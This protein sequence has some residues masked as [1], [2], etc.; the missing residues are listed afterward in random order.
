MNLVDFI[1]FDDLKLSDIDT[2]DM[3]VAQNKIDE[4]FKKNEHDTYNRITCPHCLQE[5]E[6]DNNIKYG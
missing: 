5:F 1:K 6:L 2:Q 4:K 3:Q